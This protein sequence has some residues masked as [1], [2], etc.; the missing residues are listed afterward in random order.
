M[1]SFPKNVSSSLGE[2]EF[3]DSICNKTNA[4]TEG[5]LKSLLEPNR[6][7]ITEVTGKS[8]NFQEYTNMYPLIQ[9]SVHRTHY[10]GNLMVIYLSRTAGNKTGFL[11]TSLCFKKTKMGGGRE[12]SLLQCI[13]G[14]QQEK[15]ERDERWSHWK[16]YG[17][18]QCGIWP[19]SSTVM[20]GHLSPLGKW[21]TLAQISSRGRRWDF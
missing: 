15:H 20:K 21:W 3:L 1:S 13:N 6:S 5:I 2:C 14:W 19:A 11:L 7:L 8:L 4:P 9:I 12:S 16:D 18:L 17:A 10:K